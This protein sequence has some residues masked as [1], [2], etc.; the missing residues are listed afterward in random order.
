MADY[1]E[2]PEL[3]R[4]DPLVI[5]LT[6][7]SLMIANT[8]FSAECVSGLA[9]KGF[10]IYAS[11]VGNPIYEEE[12]EIS[13][14]SSYDQ[15]INTI[16]N[17]VNDWL[18]KLQNSVKSPTRTVQ[19]TSIKDSIDRAGWQLHYDL[20]GKTD[21]QT[22]ADIQWYSYYVDAAGI[23]QDSVDRNGWQLHYD[24]VGAN[25]TFNQAVVYWTTDN[26]HHVDD[27]GTIEGAILNTRDSIDRTKDSIDRAGWQ[28]H[29]DLVGAVYT[30]DDTTGFWTSNHYVDDSGNIQDAILTI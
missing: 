4:F 5:R 9:F 26:Q 24:L 23:M 16:K 2:Y 25:C 19:M 27:S 1:P 22:F 11:C 8:I 30:F 6:D 3:I 29:H 28:Q 15:S 10:R 18:I 21:G 17:K 12:V 7:T 14:N 13:Q 20:V